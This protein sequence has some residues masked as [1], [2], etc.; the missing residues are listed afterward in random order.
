MHFS[1]TRRSKTTTRPRSDSSARLLLDTVEGVAS[2]GTAVSWVLPKVARIS[3]LACKIEVKSTQLQATPAPLSTFLTL[4]L[5]G[6]ALPPHPAASAS[7]TTVRPHQI[8]CHSRQQQRLRAL[9]STTAAATAATTTCKA[10]F[11]P[12]ATK[13]NTSFIKVPRQK[14]R[15]LPHSSCTQREKPDTKCMQQPASLAADGR[16]R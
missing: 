10:A 4:G 8:H 1:F 15:G 7:C 5:R 16:L 13:D 3:A 6:W 12:R 9:P 2:T 14:V 11:A